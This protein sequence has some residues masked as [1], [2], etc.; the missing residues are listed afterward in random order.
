M[1]SDLLMENMFFI[2][3]FGIEII[4]GNK[5]IYYLFVR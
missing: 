1:S 5:I 3:D 4:R 2:F